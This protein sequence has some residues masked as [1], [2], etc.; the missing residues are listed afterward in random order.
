[1]TFKIFDSINSIKEEQWNK[2]VHENDPFNNYHFYKALEESQSIGVDRGFSPKILTIFDGVDLV[3][4]MVVYA[5]NHSYG[6]YIFDWSWAE[7]Y[8]KHNYRY[9][10]KLVSQ[11]PFSPVT[12]RTI[13]LEDNKYLKP[14]IDELQ[15]ISNEQIYSSTHLLFLEEEELDYFPNNYKIRHSFQYHWKNRNYESFNSFLD[16]IKTKK[17]KQILKERKTPL[18]IKEV[19]EEELSQYSSIFY[20]LYIN[21]ITKKHSHPY[22]NEK[23]FKY[24]FTHMKKNILLNIAIENDSI[25]AASLFFK[26]GE[27][28][29]GRYW[30]CLKDYE[31]LHFE[32][33]YYQG[34]EYCID[35][36]INTF[37]AGAQGEHKIQRGF[38]PV[39]TYSA[40]NIKAPEFR[41]PIESFIEE[42]KQQ[43]EELLPELSK[44]LP[45]KNLKE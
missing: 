36:K 10:P 18:M 40:H 19:P 17:K 1:M 7:F 37:E 30:G 33:C 5:K 32:L 13:L 29:Y 35:N 8:Q 31:N 14:I 45:F 43:I 16:T 2:L 15:N 20:D 22:L 44:K 26:G 4:A 42:E 23:F 3:A 6:E 12:N 39:L 28:L 11:N 21:T 41:A 24:I 25:V 9:Y 38:I 34:I 27:K